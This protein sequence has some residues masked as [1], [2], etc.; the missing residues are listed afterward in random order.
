MT[1]KKI[2][3][4][5]V[6]MSVVAI[7]IVVAM[8]IGA[9]FVGRSIFTRK[10][11]TISYNDIVYT[12]PDFNEIDN[13]FEK[14]IDEAKYGS[15]SS[16]ISAMNDATSKFNELV[17]Y[18]G[19]ANI[20]YQKDYTNKTWENEY[21]VLS[22]QYT[23]S[24]LDYYTM[25]YTALHG[26][27]S[28]AIF[29]GWSQSDLD[30]IDSEY[31]ALTG[32][33]NYVEN[34]NKITELQNEYNNLGNGSGGSVFASE[35]SAREY[36]NEAGD[37]L[38][39]MAKLYN[40]IHP[41]GSYPAYAYSSYGREYTPSDVTEMR[42]Y[43][44]SLGHYVVDL[45][46][47]LGNDGMSVSD[48]SFYKEENGQVVDDVDAADAFFKKAQEVALKMFS[49]I[50]GKDATDPVSSSMRGYLTEAFDYMNDYDLYYASRNKNGNTGAFTTYLSG[51]EIPYMFQYRWDV[52]DDITT[53]VHEFGHF[54][55]YYL[56]GSNG[57]TD[58]DIAEVQSQGLEMLF[59]NYYEDVYGGLNVTFEDGGSYTG[60]ALAEIMA[61][62]QVQ[63]V[64]LNSVVFGCIMDELQ[65]DVYTNTEN[66]TSG[67]DVTEKYS[68]LLLE[69]GL[70]EQFT[71][72]YSHLLGWSYNFL[73]YWWA[74]V[75]HTFNQPFYYISYAMSAI[76]ALSLYAESTEDFASAAVSYNTVQ[77]Y[78]SGNSG[79]T[80]ETILDK[81]GI[82]SPFEKS[83]YDEI[84]VVLD[85]F[86]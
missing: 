47:D 15:S 65:Y 19:Y 30:S 7:V 67:S 22:A 82:G 74:S 48:T 6:V 50:D 4:I 66:Y 10:R 73:E 54:T 84:A 13:A 41:D 69:Y 8:I 37:L 55:A 49:V 11:G 68:E 32:S 33:G 42:S 51:F 40:E 58:L 77:Y 71:L 2:K 29:R 34:Q 24:Y 86:L 27:N 78:G 17:S 18:L 62:A 80:F 43:V 38:I 85:S 16:A 5:S 63:S 61:E 28:T 79:Y 26:P 39:R 59:V 31:E 83:T 57:S 52:I 70:T 64:L 36:S 45:Y 20:E 72:D 12:R 44:K 75:S 46:Y 56:S 23:K 9:V 25:L 53:F 76:P 21:T 60:A 1:E 3:I 81:A 14:A 35:S